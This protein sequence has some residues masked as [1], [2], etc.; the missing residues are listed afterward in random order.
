MRELTAYQE[1]NPI[2]LKD[3]DDKLITALGLEHPIYEKTWFCTPSEFL[4]LHAS[5]E[6][7]KLDALDFWA[8]E[9][10]LNSTFTSVS[11]E[12]EMRLNIQRAKSELLKLGILSSSVSFEGCE[13]ST[14]WEAFNEAFR[15]EFK[16]LTFDQM[17]DLVKEVMQNVTFTFS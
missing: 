9:L 5:L 1:K 12:A 3:L 15:L 10:L 7:K 2:S 14:F 17:K 8:R 16:F 4:D 13:N 6:Q 11:K